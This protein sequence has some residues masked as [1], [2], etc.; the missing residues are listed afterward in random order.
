MKVPRGGAGLIGGPMDGGQQSYLAKQQQILMNNS[1]IQNNSGTTSSQRLL[2]AASK[3][4]GVVDREIFYQQA[5]HTANQGISENAKNNKRYNNSG[6]QQKQKVQKTQQNN[7]INKGALSD[8]HAAALISEGALSHL[9]NSHIN[10]GDTIGSTQQNNMM[11]SGGHHQQNDSF[12][13]AN[14]AFWTRKQNEYKANLIKNN[15]KQPGQNSILSN[16]AHIMTHLMSLDEMDLGSDQNGGTST[17]PRSPHSQQK[18]DDHRSGT[19]G[20]L[21]NQQ[22]S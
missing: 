16:Q 20:A 15:D 13:N 1:E 2:E 21:L 8:Q 5:Q 6:N 3:P 10:E 17:N 18:F 22:M 11:L 14:L 12:E 9:I 4:A 19:G 7:V